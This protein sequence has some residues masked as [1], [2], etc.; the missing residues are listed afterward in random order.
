MMNLQETKSVIKRELDMLSVEAAKLQDHLNAGFAENFSEAKNAAQS[1]IDQIT[2]A[3]KQAVNEAERLRERANAEV[4]RALANEE[5]RKALASEEARRVQKYVEE[6]F[7]GHTLA[8]PRADQ[9][10]AE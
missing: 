2:S 1:G 3:A 7:G 10:Q 4:R 8:A 5:V 6:R 9:E